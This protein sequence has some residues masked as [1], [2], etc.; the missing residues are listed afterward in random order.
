M[1]FLISIVSCSKCYYFSRTY[2]GGNGNAEFDS[3]PFLKN[4]KYMDTRYG[5]L[6]RVNLVSYPFIRCYI[7]DV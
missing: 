4:M 1:I 6:T 2:S 5:N 7:I 3:A